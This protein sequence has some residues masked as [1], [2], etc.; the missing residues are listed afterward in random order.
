MGFCFAEGIGGKK[1]ADQARVWYVKAAD[2][3]DQKAIEA[4]EV[5]DSRKRKSG[6]SDNL[7]VLALAAKRLCEEVQGSPVQRAS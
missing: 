6:E 4:L 3:G 5:L 1:D 7:N 2:G